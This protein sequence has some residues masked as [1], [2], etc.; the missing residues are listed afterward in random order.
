M[1]TTLC[2]CPPTAAS[3]ARALRVL[4]L[5]VLASAQRCWDEHAAPVLPELRQLVWDAVQGLTAPPPAPAPPAGS[6]AVLLA[7]MQCEAELLRAMATVIS[8]LRDT[9]GATA[10]DRAAAASV[11]RIAYDA[12]S[13]LN[14]L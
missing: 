6:A 5:N 10:A 12:I 8:R 13:R 4:T 14:G 1:L 9:A 3:H 11:R 2:G 7:A